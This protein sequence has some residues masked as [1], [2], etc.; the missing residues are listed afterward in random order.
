MLT[1]NLV[2]TAAPLF[3][4]ATFTLISTCIRAP[5]QTNYDGPLGPS[6]KDFHASLSAV[7]FTAILFAGIGV[8]LP[9]G[10]M[11]T[12]AQQADASMERVERL[13]SDSLHQVLVGRRSNLNMEETHP[14][15]RPASSNYDDPESWGGSTRRPS[16]TV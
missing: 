16:Y 7:Q 3:L 13:T 5:P 12:I 2:L 6:G 11:V 1:N 4:A 10:G 9:L 15:A 14:P 8:V